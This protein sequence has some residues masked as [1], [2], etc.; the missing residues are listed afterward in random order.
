MDALDA[1]YRV[2]MARV[3]FTV[4]TRWPVD[5]E[6]LWAALTDWASHGD[7]VPATSVRLL[8]GAGEVGTRFV[9][10]TGVGP[11]A[12]DDHMTVTVLDPMTR[13]AVVEKTGPLL[14]GEAGFSIIETPTGCQLS[15]FED[16]TVPRAPKA[17]GWVATYPARASFVIA[18]SRLRR[19]LTRQHGAARTP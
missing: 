10:R 15:W 12:F 6:R 14:F 7:W 17:L 13:R 3:T 9:A 18:L 1:G 16:V 5:G 4:N 11:L 2:P 8:H 19:Q